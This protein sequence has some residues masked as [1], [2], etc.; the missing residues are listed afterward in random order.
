MDVFQR[1]RGPITSVAPCGDGQLVTAAYDGAV[2]LYDL[3]RSSVE[4]LGYHRHLVNKVI[5]DVAHGRAA[6]CSS[7]YTVRIWSIAQKRCVRE[8]RGHSDDVED[9]VFVDGRTGISASRDRRI[10]IWDLDTGAIRRVIDDHDRDVLSLAFHEGRLFSSGDDKTLR[11]WSI[12]TGRCL[13]QWGPFEH[14]TDTCAINS[15]R[16]HVVLGCDDGVVRVFEIETGA[17]V[18]GLPAHT[19]GIKKVAVAPNGDF[20]TAAYDQKIAVWDGTTLAERVVLDNVPTKWE[21]SFTWSQDGTRIYAGTFD[22]TVL[23]WDATTGRCLREVGAGAGEPGNACFN[24][25]SGTAHGTIVAVADDGYV[26]VGELGRATFAT[27]HAPCS[28]RMLMNALAID[29]PR[30]RVAAGAHDQKL[31]LFRLADWELV[32]EIEVKLGEGPINSIAFSSHA[33]TEGDAFA[34]CY[35]GAVCRVT[36]TGEVAA[37]LRVHDGAVKAVR[38]HPR[39]PLGISCSAAGTMCSWTFTGEVIERYLGHTAIIN[40]I[41]LEP[42]GARLASVSR[43]FTLKIYEVESGR[44]QQSIALGRRSLKAVCF[45]SQDL[46]LVGDY[47]GHLIRVELT[48]GRA[49]R[50]AIARNGISS[51]GRAGDLVVAASY[52]GHIYAVRSDTLESVHTIEAMRQRVEQEEV[53]IA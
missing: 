16:G 23:E 48:T 52:D 51:I 25:V 36:P 21:R 12:E 19:S 20:L 39:K 6:T 43:D 34:A 33:G 3:G 53:E 1:H 4:L 9:F 32:D 38:L 40:D 45:V 31:H 30:R 5:S 10:L 14:E 27:K 11:V 18:K 50:K 35:S 2:A 42:S 37:R 28:G 13:H 17:L 8:L 24:R 7:D 49:T 44:L 15:V 41:D 26:R 29:E 22:G 47:W 46:V